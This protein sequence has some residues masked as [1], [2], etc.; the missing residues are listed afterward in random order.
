MKLPSPKFSADG[1]AQFEFINKRAIGFLKKGEPVISVDTK[2]KE[3]VGNF[4]NPGQEYRPKKNARRVEGHD[5]SDKTAAPYGVYDMAKNEGFVN[6]GQN[7]DTSEFAV[8]SIRKW[9]RLVGRAQYPEAKELLITADGGGSNGYRCKQW[10]Y[11]LQRFANDSGLSVS[12]CHFPPGTSKW[13]KI[14]HRLFSHISLNWRG[15]PLVDYETIVKLIGETK[16]AKGLKV[17]CRLDKKRYQKGIE[18]T[19]DELESIH[20]KKHNF[21]GEWNYTIKPNM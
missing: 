5:F 14:E 18:I 4:K 7:Y 3:N 15:V 10:K 17:R 8:N 9:W 6:V 19:D 12:V 11:E 1:N 2:K 13:N 21:H 20:L 16:T